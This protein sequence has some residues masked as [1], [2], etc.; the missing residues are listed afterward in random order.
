ML[1]LHTVGQT[2][3]LPVDQDAMTLM[4]HQRHATWLKELYKR[5]TK[6]L[7]FSLR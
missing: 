2:V 7:D 4:L 3:A 5:D 6:I 1:A